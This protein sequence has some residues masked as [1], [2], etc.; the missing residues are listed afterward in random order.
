MYPLRIRFCRLLYLINRIPCQI[1]QAM[2][3]GNSA[4]CVAAASQAG[5]LQ[6]ILA[7]SKALAAKLGVTPAAPPPTP[8]KAKK[9]SGV[10]P[11]P[12]KAAQPKNLPKS[13]VPVP[14]QVAENKAVPDVP[15]AKASA[16]KPATKSPPA[17]AD[18][19]L[20]AAKASA[21]PSAPAA[22]P[23]KSA[24]SQKVSVEG[25]GA[26]PASA[27][28]TPLES[29][30]L[31][32]TV[33]ENPLTPVKSAELPSALPETALP[34]ETADL[35]TQVPFCPGTS[36][37][38]TVMEATPS[39]PLIQQATPKS[40]LFFLVGHCFTDFSAPTLIRFVAV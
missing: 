8:A 26:L 25:P 18:T 10:P 38:S 39:H 28:P 20:P 27:L 12:A 35:Q 6:K 1:A 30:D 34:V 14:K 19:Q 5:D 31:Q 17:P 40:M 33:P 22:P 16:P 23:P 13:S 29:A 21:K 37:A 9:A 32:A 24:P 11:A 4:K 3:K 2:A 36:Q 15:S 7:A